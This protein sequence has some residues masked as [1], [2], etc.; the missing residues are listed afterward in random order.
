MNEFIDMWDFFKEQ[1][2]KFKEYQDQYFDKLN[3]YLKEFEDNTEELFIEEQKIFLSTSI[4]T[5]NEILL[6]SDEDP[7]AEFMSLIEARIATLKKIKLFLDSREKI[8]E[9]NFLNPKPQEN[10]VEE[11]PKN[12]RKKPKY[13]ELFENID[14]LALYLFYI[15]EEV[16]RPNHKDF[17]KKW[18]CSGYKLYQKFND[19]RK[20]GYRTRSRGTEIK[21]RNHKERLENVKNV[22]PDGKRLV[23]ETDLKDFLKNS[24]WL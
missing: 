12:P 11:K 19:Y 6:E 14:E 22:L 3:L 7:G 4:K 10:S 2:P 8:A 20:I 9:N 17:G 13:K 15:E 24:N 21:D 1:S 16:N 18:E 23:I 5:I